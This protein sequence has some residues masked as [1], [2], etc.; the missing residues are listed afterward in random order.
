MFGS[1][2][3]CVSL[4]ATRI[5]WCV[6]TLVGFEGDSEEADGVWWTNDAVMEAAVS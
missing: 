4:A 3:W 2:V 5:S 1:R 6:S